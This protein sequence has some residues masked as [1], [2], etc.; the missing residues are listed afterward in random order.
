MHYHAKAPVEGFSTTG[1]TLKEAAYLLDHLCGMEPLGVVEC[2]CARGEEECDLVNV[3]GIPV[4][5]EWSKP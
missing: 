4:T 1:R 5:E 2:E 3:M